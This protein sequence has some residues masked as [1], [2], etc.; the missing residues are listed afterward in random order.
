MAGEAQN[1]DWPIP[2]FYFMVDWGLGED[3]PFQEVD[4]LDIDS[5]LIEYRHSNSPVFSKINM[6]GLVKNGSV[7]LKKGIFVNDNSFR[8]WYQKIKMNTIERQNVVIKLIDED[9]GAIM[10]W[11]IRN[12]WP[13]KI[14]ATNQKSDATEVAVEYIEIAHEGLTIAQG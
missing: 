8:D 1:N 13:T 11:I 2:R 4:G 14:T 7:T 10:T 5:K 3:I 6:P 9:G 12:A